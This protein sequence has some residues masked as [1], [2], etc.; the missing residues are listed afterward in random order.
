MNRPLI[1]QFSFY[2]RDQLWLWA[3]AIGLPFL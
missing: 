3:A 1:P 2:R